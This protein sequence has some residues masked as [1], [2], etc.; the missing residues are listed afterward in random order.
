MYMYQ[1]LTLPKLIL[2]IIHQVK[3][4]EIIAMKEVD[5]FYFIVYSIVSVSNT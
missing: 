4:K 3:T 2:I 5:N 1:Y